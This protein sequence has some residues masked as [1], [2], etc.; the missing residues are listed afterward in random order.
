[1]FQQKR[2][3]S[4]EDWRRNKQHW[5]VVKEGDWHEWGQKVG[6]DQITQG[7]VQCLD[8]FLTK[9]KSLQKVVSRED[10]TQLMW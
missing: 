4:E 2:I 7:C 3:I 10:M 9:K 1:M 5:Y 8:F 6:R